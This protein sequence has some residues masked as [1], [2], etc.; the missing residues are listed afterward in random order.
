M[1]GNNRGFIDHPIPMYG[2]RFQTRLECTAEGTCTINKSSCNRQIVEEHEYGF[3]SP[4]KALDFAV[5]EVLKK[6][7]T[8]LSLEQ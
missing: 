6:G 3:T 1:T 2:V 7:A 8:L 4:E 5:H